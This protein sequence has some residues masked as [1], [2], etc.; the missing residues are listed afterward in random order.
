MLEKLFGSKT[1]VK[2]LKLFLLHPE[3]RLYMRQI[4]RNLKLQINSV[5]RELENLEDLDILVTASERTEPAGE[6]KADKK[7]ARAP[8]AKDGG[9]QDKKFFQINRAFVLHEELRALIVKAQILYEKDFIK[10][11][12]AA[13]QIKLL[14]F[15]GRFVNMPAA[16][17]DILIVG[18]FHKPRFY[19]L[20]KELESELGWE[21][22]FTLMGT[23]EFKYRRDITDVFLYNILEGKKIVVIDELG[24]N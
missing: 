14:V 4:A 19:K 7:P 2:I 3:D 21:I 9:K 22:N 18:R 20:I 16:A 13:G 10:K 8:L 24:A 11:L 6:K 17:V 15:T 12:L 5:R 1:R 23:K